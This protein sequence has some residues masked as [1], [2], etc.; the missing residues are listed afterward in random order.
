MRSRSTI[1]TIPAAAYPGADLLLLQKTMGHASVTV[2]AHVYADLYDDALDGIASALDSLDDGAQ[3]R[4]R[5]FGRITG[6]RAP[7]P[8]TT[9]RTS[10]NQEWPGPGSNRRP[11]AFRFSL[12]DTRR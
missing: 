6:H 2:T 3:D 10:D 1:R 9:V 7:H 11:S 5:R 8:P 4:S 12:F